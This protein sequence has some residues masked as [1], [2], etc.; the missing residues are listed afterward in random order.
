[1]AVILNKEGKKARIDDL[2]VKF[3]KTAVIPEP[4]VT[5]LLGVVGLGLFFRRERR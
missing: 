2:G 3:T 5:L 4:S 1:M